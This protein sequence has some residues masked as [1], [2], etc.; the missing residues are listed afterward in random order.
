MLQQTLQLPSSG[1]TSVWGGGG[2]GIVRKHILDLAVG[3]ECEV[4]DVIG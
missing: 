3:D 4:T 2:G 1:L